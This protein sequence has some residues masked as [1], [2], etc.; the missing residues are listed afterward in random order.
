LQN[1]NASALLQ[2]IETSWA[3]ANEGYPFLPVIDGPNGLLPDLPSVLMEKGKF[4]RVPFIAGANLDEG[5]ISLIH[6]YPIANI[7]V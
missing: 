3:K 2:G 1:A 6:A 4:A 7:L 5:A